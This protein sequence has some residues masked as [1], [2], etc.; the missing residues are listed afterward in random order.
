[1]NKANRTYSKALTKS[2]ISDY[3]LHGNVML[4][5]KPGLNKQVQNKKA[6]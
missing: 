5:I 3:Q 6:K 2:N 4:K 1:M